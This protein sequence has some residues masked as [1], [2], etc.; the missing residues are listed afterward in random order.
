MSTR[1]RRAREAT[2]P[3]TAWARRRAAM[4]RPWLV[5]GSSRKSRGRRAGERGTAGGLYLPDGA[6]PAR[7]DPLPGTFDTCGIVSFAKPLALRH[8]LAGQALFV[9]RFGES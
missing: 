4:P 8:L 6:I 3:G 7:L 1:W 9:E 5:S 2:A